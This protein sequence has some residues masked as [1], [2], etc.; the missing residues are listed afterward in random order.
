MITNWGQTGHWEIEKTLW[1]SSIE[2]TVLKR[3]LHILIG[4]LKILVHI[5]QL[6][7]VICF[8]MGPKTSILVH[9]MDYLVRMECQQKR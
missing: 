4:I 1:G 9:G 2:Q 6:A 5:N 7:L 3:Q 8:F